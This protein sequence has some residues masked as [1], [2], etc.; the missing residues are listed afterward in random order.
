MRALAICDE[1]QIEGKNMAER[2]VYMQKSEHL[3]V[4]QATEKSDAPD[5]LVY[6][7]KIRNT[8]CPYCGISNEDVICDYDEKTCVWRDAEGKWREGY[9]IDWEYSKLRPGYAFCLNCRREFQVEEEKTFK[10]EREIDCDAQIRL[11]CP[12]CGYSWFS[13]GKTRSFRRIDKFAR[14]NIV[15]YKC[16]ACGEAFYYAIRGGKAPSPHACNVRTFKSLKDLSSWQSYRSRFV[17]SVFTPYSWNVEHVTGGK[18]EGEDIITPEKRIV[19]AAFKAYLHREKFGL[20][21]TK[22]ERALADFERRIKPMIE[23]TLEKVCH[24][25]LASAL[26]ED[27][28][29]YTRYIWLDIN[30]MGRTPEL[31]VLAVIHYAYTMIASKIE[32]TEKRQTFP[33]QSFWSFLKSNCGLNLKTYEK[34]VDFVLDALQVARF[35]NPD[36]VKRRM[37]ALIDD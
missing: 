20:T 35:K 8:G 14:Y 27:A 37:F 13:Y 10:I 34:N 4:M 16:L 18:R 5:K 7:I 2:D 26:R 22:R 6:S 31:I 33:I 3:V 24:M 32:D 25:E 17:T 1:G 36:A 9:P 28:I 21:R 30:K 11:K 12:N 15:G 23:L 29:R 19:K